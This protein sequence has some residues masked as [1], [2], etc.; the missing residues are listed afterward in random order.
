VRSRLVFGAIR[1]VLAVGCFIRAAA[2]GCFIR[3]AV[4]LIRAAVHLIRAAVYLIRASVY[5]IRASVCFIRVAAA[6]SFD[7]MSQSLF[8]MPALSRMPSFPPFSLDRFF[9]VARLSA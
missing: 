8:G 4:H 5:L 7:I 6:P 9:L 2:V 1:F 3:A